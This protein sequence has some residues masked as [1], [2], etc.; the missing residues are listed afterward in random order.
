MAPTVAG[1]ARR[2]RDEHGRVSCRVAQGARFS[3]GDA[4]KRKGR[5]GAAEPAERSGSAWGAPSASSPH[6]HR[7]RC[8]SEQLCVP[9]ASPCAASGCAAAG[10]GRV[11]VRSGG[12]VA[13]VSRAWAAR[14]GYRRRAGDTQGRCTPSI[15]I[16]I[17][18]WTLVPHIIRT[19]HATWTQAGQL[20][21]H[22]VRHPRSTGCAH[23][24]AAARTPRGQTGDPT[25]VDT[26][27]SE[28]ASAWM[29]GVKVLSW[30]WGCNRSRG[31]RHDSCG[32]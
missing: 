7:V 11:A 19:P 25:S 21:N 24:T 23:P 13:C 12:R 18:F 3:A 20:N 8:S 4:E 29:G 6:A 17:S 16:K 15:Y 10:A 14:G 28:R 32:E 26:W 9:G 31:A 2:W 5:A 22:T 30:T 27:A 1:A